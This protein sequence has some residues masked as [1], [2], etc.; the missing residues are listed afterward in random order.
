MISV[1]KKKLNEYESLEQALLEN[2][3]IEGPYWIDINM[4]KEKDFEI[5]KEHFRFHPIAIE[6]CTEKVKR[7]KIHD[8][9]DYKFITV[10]SSGDVTKGV[11]NYKNIH[12]FINEKF[13][14][15]IHHNE[16]K[17]I[18][19]LF[20]ELKNESNIFSSGT[21][22]IMY[23]ILDEIVDQYF[24][25]TDKLENQI[26]LLEEKAMNNPV[27]NTVTEI[28]STKKSVMKL[29]R[30]VSPIRELL[31]TLLRHDDI[32]SEANRIY[33]SDLYD[34]ILRIYDF[35]ESEQEMIT[36]CLELY[37]SQLSNSMNK[38]MKFLTIITTIMMPL[39]IITGLYGMNFDN[40][41]E[42]H[43]KYGYFIVIFGMLFIT[44]CQIIIIFF[45][46]RK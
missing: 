18:K 46:K 10:T 41:P 30:V 14:I 11:F 16:N 36:S 13:V 26:D 37:S 9:I 17:I 20:N 43:Y 3:S 15:T 33:Y 38:V 44:I 34:H 35:I 21:D 28:M 42:L 1:I 8:Y 27:Q 5:L 45:R 25:L 2:K 24:I 4:P 32:I 23:R 12:I 31:N 40:M 19:R 39:T 29:R 22:F 6:S 7:S